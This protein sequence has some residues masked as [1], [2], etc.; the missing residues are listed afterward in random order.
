MKTKGR[1]KGTTPRNSTGKAL[2]RGAQE[3]GFCDVALKGASRETSIISGSAGCYVESMRAGRWVSRRWSVGRQASA[4]KW[5]TPV[6]EIRLRHSCSLDIPERVLSD[7]W[8][9]VSAKVAKAKRGG[10]HLVVHLSHPQPAD[11]HLDVKVHTLL[12][13]TAVLTRWLEIT[14]RTDRAV[15]LSRV[16]PWA[17]RLWDQDA[18]VRLGRWQRM[19]WGGEGWF[20]WEKLRTGENLVRNDTGQVW[21][22]SNFV[23]HNESTEE[24]FFAQMAWATQYEMAFP[25]GRSE[26]VDFRIAP[27]ASPTFYVLQPGETMNTPAVHLGCVR[28]E[29]HEA[30]QQM[31]EHIRRSVLPRRRSN[32]AYRTQYLMPGDWDICHYYEDEFNEANA[33]KCVDV[34]AE[35][36]LEVFILD[37]P[38]WCKGY[39]SWTEPN[40]KLFP[41]GI[42]PIRQRTRSKGMLLGMYFETEGGRDGDTL[43]QLSPGLIPDMGCW[44]DTAVFRDHPE[45][46]DRANLDLT[47]PEAA[48]YFRD[49]IG[50]VIEKYGLD[51]YRHDENGVV[52][53]PP[54]PGGIPT[55]RPGWIQEGRSYRHYRALHDVLRQLRAK[56]PEVAFQ[57]ASAGGYRLDIGTMSGFHEHFASDLAGSP[58]RLAGMSVFLPPEVLVNAVGMPPMGPYDLETR[59]RIGYA[60]GT[61]AMFFT[62]ALPGSLE[63]F[64]PEQ[65]NL[66]QRYAKL[67]KRFMRPL[68]GKTRV[69]HHSPV[70]A[71]G[72]INSGNWLVMEFMAPDSRKGWATVI[73]MSDKPRG[74]YQFKPRGLTPAGDYRVRFD[75]EDRTERFAGKSLAR[76]GLTITLPNGRWSQLL[77]F[78]RVDR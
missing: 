8:E 57:Q 41:N 19:S 66:Y 12:D 44:R 69:Y 10:K 65:R 58:N 25:K 30:V 75:N 48:E 54:G 60:M 23:L 13:G 63:D 28:G 17:G 52:F 71:D 4:P 70:N 46:F 40:G 39:G 64:T 34:A 37:G 22:A 50:R 27:L 47:I 49:E 56:Y 3:T 24:Y 72:G 68:L 31:H 36:G 5:E 38:T 6:F 26:G 74:E 29:F 15:G 61:T 33:L 21:D 53:Y 77:L 18:P 45:W 59:L 62:S 7:G 11:E 55:L 76:D 42:G 43:Q 14:N 32:R 1:K 2:V 78:E 67:H 35:A 20:D 16:V 73:N 9:F 51:V